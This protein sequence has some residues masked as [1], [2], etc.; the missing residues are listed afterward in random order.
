MH[1]IPQ[2]KDE[3]C[4]RSYITKILW[5]VSVWKEKHGTSTPIAW[6]AIMRSE[7]LHGKCVKYVKVF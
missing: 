2:L 6:D 1:E 5:L 7:I 4:P 3:K